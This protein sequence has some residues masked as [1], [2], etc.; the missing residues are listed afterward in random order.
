[1]KTG[2]IVADIQGDFTELKDGPLSVKGT[3]QRFIDEI[4]RNT[5][6]LKQADFPVIVTQDWHPANH[7]SFY[8]NHEGKKAF[9]T[10]SIQGQTQV[11][12]P[13]HCVQKTE[14]AALLL[15]DE[16]FDAVVRK[17]TNARY[18]S[19]SGFEDDGG[20]ET[21]LN[22]ILKEWSITNLVI[23]GV[24][25]DYC[26]EATAL[27]GLKHGY[28]VIVIKDLTRGIDPESTKSALAKME[29]GGVVVF[30]TIDL[31]KLK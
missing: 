18:D 13:P 7:V 15:D 12:W 31:N 28:N 8:T 1:M 21:P 23:Y 19:Y 26:V 2:I 25:T 29:Q 10:I 3:D 6:M 27:D 4:I 17:G 14:G 24:A 5:R 20:F 16:L 9:D 30:D 22:S 11:L